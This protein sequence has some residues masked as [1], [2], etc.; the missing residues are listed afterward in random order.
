MIA[1]IDGDILCYRL[2][3]ANQGA[4][5]ALCRANVDSYLENMLLWQLGATECEGFLTVDSRDNFRIAI[6]TTLP[7]KGNRKGE[8]P[9][10]YDFIRSYLLSEDGW[11]FTGVRGEEA[12]DALGKW[13]TK[14]GDEAVICTIDKDLDMI[15]G[16]HYNFVK[17]LKYYVGLSE[18]YRSFCTQLLL[19]D[20]T[21]NIS[22]IRGCGP[23]GASRII[24][25]DD[26]FEIQLRRV[27]EEYRKADN[28]SIQ[29][30]RENC[31]LLWIRRNFDGPELIEQI[32]EKDY[33]S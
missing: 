15:P 1:L 16:W 33:A 27:S 6:A 29:R 31:R 22:G 26:D 32:L 8:K 19:G 10:H 2:G 24:K 18:G 23:V 13:A 9:I 3:F 5:Q 11:S 30:F 12:D 20:R 14:L 21:D 7:Y 25:E 4:S 28:G 17:R